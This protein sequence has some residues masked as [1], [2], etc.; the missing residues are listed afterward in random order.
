MEGSSTKIGN[1]RIAS[2]KGNI[3]QG[4]IEG[5]EFPIRSGLEGADEAGRSI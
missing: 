5:A 4:K 1:N 2:E 3:V